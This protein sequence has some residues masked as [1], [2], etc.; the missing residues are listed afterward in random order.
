M[1][2]FVVGDVNPENIRDIVETHENKGIRRI[3][4]ALNEQLLMNQQML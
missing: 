4:L 2:L 1:V 3:S